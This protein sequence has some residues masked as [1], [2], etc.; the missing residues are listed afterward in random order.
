MSQRKITIMSLSVILLFGCV[1]KVLAQGGKQPEDPH[2]KERKALEDDIKELDSKIVEKCTSLKDT[3]ISADAT[4]SEFAYDHNEV[5]TYFDR[6]CPTGKLIWTAERKASQDDLEQANYKLTVEAS[7]AHQLGNS[8]PLSDGFVQLISET[9]SIK[10]D[11]GQGNSKQQV[12]WGIDLREDEFAQKFVLNLK[13]LAAALKKK[14]DT[15]KKLAALPAPP[16]PETPPARK[17]RKK[18]S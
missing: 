13:D 11:D 12:K 17:K 18:R 3:I 7:A 15:A 4:S 10:V 9:A 2:A 16:A 1:A 5:D 6:D 8:R 14:I